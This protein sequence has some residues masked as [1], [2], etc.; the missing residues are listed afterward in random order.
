MSHSAALSLRS[1]PPFV[2]P[3]APSRVPWCRLMPCDAVFAACDFVHRLPQ[4]PE[5]Y[6]PSPPPAFQ[7]RPLNTFAPP[8]PCRTALLA[9]VSSPCFTATCRHSAAARLT[10]ITRPRAVAPNYAP[11]R[12]LVSRT[13]GSSLELRHGISLDSC[14]ASRRLDSCCAACRPV[15]P[16]HALS[17]PMAPPRRALAPHGAMLLAV[18]P[19]CAAPRRLDRCLAPRRSTPYCLVP[20]ALSRA[21]SP[22]SPFACAR[23]CTV[24]LLPR[25]ALQCFEIV[26]ARHAVSRPLQH[27]RPPAP[28]LVLSS[29]VATGG[30]IFTPRCAV[31]VPRR[32]APSLCCP[33]FCRHPSAAAVTRSRSASC[34]VAPQSEPRHAAIVRLNGAITLRSRASCRRR[35]TAPCRRVAIN[36]FA[37]V[38]TLVPSCALCRCRHAP[39][40]SHLKPLAQLSRDLAPL[41][42]R[43]HTPALAAASSRHRSNPRAVLCAAPC[44]RAASSR[45]TFCHLPGSMSSP[46]PRATSCSRPSSCGWCLAQ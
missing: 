9:A 26:A 13:P 15:A 37:A 31:F 27:R 6:A 32:A 2:R 21:W 20:P 16:H 8:A 30:V 18:V 42:H 25:S 24:S 23:V 34:A 28:C 17:C 14:D 5:S 45:L 35:P 38:S 1:V 40:F 11:R 41:S 19:Y 29:R 43:H 7:R 46:A 39:S 12:T 22:I 36:P 44:P 33:V 10:A 3:A 4:P